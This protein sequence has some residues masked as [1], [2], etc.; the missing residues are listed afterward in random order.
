MTT[1][2]YSVKTQVSYKGEIVNEF[3]SNLVNFGDFQEIIDN[4]CWIDNA[5]DLIESDQD[6]DINPNECEYLV[7]YGRFVVEHDQQP[8]YSIHL[9]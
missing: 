4:Q 6:C 5:K 8:K 9:H 3:L 1:L 2:I 7:S